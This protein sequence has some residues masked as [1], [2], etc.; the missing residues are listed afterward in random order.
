MFGKTG[1]GGTLGLTT[2]H[3]GPRYILA[4]PL[5]GMASFLLLPEQGLFGVR[6]STM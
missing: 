2:A 5:R 1:G 6:V 4:W 3:Y